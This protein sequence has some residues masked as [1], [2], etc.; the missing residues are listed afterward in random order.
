MDFLNI[1][2]FS[3][4]KSKL[5]YMSQRQSILAENIANADTPRYKAQDIAE[6]DFKKMLSTVDGSG[7]AQRLQMRT[8]NASHIVS[9][10]GP[11]TRF[12]TIDR[13]FT[14]EL[15]PNE[16]NVALEEEVAKV[17]LNQAEYQKVLNLYTKTIGMF[18]LAIGH[19]NG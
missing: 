8:T 7:S 1:P 11:V 2:L 6:P 14:D 4:M 15:N 10:M 17:G 5:T 18:K 13:P 16:N 3:I 12:Q 19:Q 9:G